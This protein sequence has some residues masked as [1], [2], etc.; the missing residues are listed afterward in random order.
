MM[1]NKEDTVWQHVWPE[2]MFSGDCIWAENWMNWKNEAHI[3]L[4]GIILQEKE[5]TSAV[6]GVETFLVCLQTNSEAHMG[7]VEWVRSGWAE[8]GF[9]WHQR[10][11]QP[12]PVFLTQKSHEQRSLVACS[13][14]GHKRLDIT[15]LLTTTQRPWSKQLWSHDN[16]YGLNCVPIHPNP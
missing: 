6:S 1:R 7:S 3:Y 14:K 13:A 11:C 9:R 8:T 16:C 4:Q 15:E 12:T 5:I 10:K 2:K